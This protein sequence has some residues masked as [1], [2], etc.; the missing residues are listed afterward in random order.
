MTTALQIVDRRMQEASDQKLGAIYAQNDTMERCWGFLLA[1]LVQIKC[2][3]EAG[4]KARPG[5]SAGGHARARAL[6]DAR[7]AEIASNAA[8]A[9]WDASKSGETRAEEVGDA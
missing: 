9:R 6:S 7:K 3:I 1:H 5:P 4:N 2:E 8:R